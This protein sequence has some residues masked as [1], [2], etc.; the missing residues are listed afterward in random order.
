NR[1]RIEAA[2][3]DEIATI[4]QRYEEQ[5]KPLGDDIRQL[6][7][8]V[9]VWCEANREAITQGGKVKF[10]TLT[11]GKVNWRTR[12]PKVTLRGKESILEN[13]KRLG[14]AR[15]VRTSEEINKEA[16]LN[17]P[18]LAK[19]VPGVNITQGEDFVIT[20]FETELEEV[21]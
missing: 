10:A 13:L 18:A 15:F 19:T 14:L 20:P 16:M 11:T 2:M 7:Q 21:A 17:E 8:G 1:G 12:P 9:Q 6:S 3:N 4:K 5:A